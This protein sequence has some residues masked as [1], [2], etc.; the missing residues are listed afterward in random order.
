MIINR[1]SWHYR[2][3]KTLES[4]TGDYDYDPKSLCTYF[5]RLVRLQALALI[6]TSFCL[7]VVSAIPLLLWSHFRN[8]SDGAGV[9]LVAIAVVVGFISTIYIICKL[10]DRLRL[11]T[12]PRHLTFLG[13]I[14]ETAKAAKNKV[15]PLVKYE[16]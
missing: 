15:C 9:V 11:G 12:M 10:N 2:W 5:W 4:Y 6:F 16:E 8:G 14:I 7:G 3:L 13:V 1:K